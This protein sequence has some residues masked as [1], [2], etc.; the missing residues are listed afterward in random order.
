VRSLRG[1]VGLSSRV[2]Q[3]AAAFVALAAGVAACGPSIDAAAKADVDRR[4]ASL[5][6]PTATFAA[7]GGFVPMALVP[8]QW[9]QHKMVNDKGEPSFLTYKV[10]AEENGATWV[11]VVS[12]GYT[13][14]TIQKMLVAFGNRTDINQIEIRA[15]KMKDV[16]GN[17]NE[18]PGPALSMMQSLYRGALSGL[19]IS[20]QGMPQEAASVPAG[21]FDG[22]FRTRTEAQWGGWKSVN[23][24]WSHT[25]V[26]ISGMVKS[27]G[28]DKPFTMELVAFGLTG[29]TSEL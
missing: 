8:G 26:P 21:R 9:T 1:L 10:L 16:K 18:I 15:L 13:G 19:V 7:P 27:Q 2:A 3:V 24:S 25:A 14:K 20:W 28:V 29:A 5:Q 11:E 17:V 4:V 6:A 22:C 12:E 23:D